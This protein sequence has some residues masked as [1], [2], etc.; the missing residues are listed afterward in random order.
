[1]QVCRT[2]VAATQKTLHS[3]HLQNRPRKRANIL[4]PVATVGEGNSV[5]PIPWMLRYTTLSR[6]PAMICYSATQTPRVSILFRLLDSNTSFNKR[7]GPKAQMAQI[8]LHSHALLTV[9]DSPAALPSLQYS[10]RQGQITTTCMTAKGTSVAA[11]TRIVKPSKAIQEQGELI[12][13]M[14]FALDP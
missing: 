7:H 12:V 4:N 10:P 14:V 5:A 1:M 9:E 6:S 13:I 8:H 2:H 11:T 3:L